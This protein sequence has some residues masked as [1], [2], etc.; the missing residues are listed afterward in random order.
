MNVLQ[1]FGDSLDANL[2]IYDEL[3]NRGGEVMSQATPAKR[4]G[5]NYEQRS[6]HG[7]TNRKDSPLRK[8]LT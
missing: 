6:M 7:T 5:D 4:Q 8:N 2:R 1:P 3:Q